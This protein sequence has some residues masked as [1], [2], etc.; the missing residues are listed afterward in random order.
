MQPDLTKVSSRK[1]PS[2]EKQLASIDDTYELKGKE[3]LFAFLAEHP[4]IISPLLELPFQISERFGLVVPKIELIQDEELPNWKTLYV[5]IP[6]QFS[7]DL[8]YEKLIDLLE[9][10]AF[11]QSSGFKKFVTISIL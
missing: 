8:G 9:N 2:R 11:N 7:F 10:W 4:A 6:H 1:K 3:I 5:K